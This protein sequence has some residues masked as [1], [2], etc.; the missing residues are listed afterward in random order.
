MHLDLFRK[1]FLRSVTKEI[2]FVPSY[3]YYNIYYETFAQ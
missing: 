1:P 3:D 2:L